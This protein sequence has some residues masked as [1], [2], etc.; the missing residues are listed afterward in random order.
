MAKIETTTAKFKAGIRLTGD[1]PE[2]RWEST[3]YLSVQLFDASGAMALAGR[4]L[5]VEIPKEG[6]VSLESDN[7][8]KVFHADV[9]FQDY[10]LDLGDGIK[11]QVPAVA[12][13]DE[14]QERHVPGIAFAFANLLV[15][16]RR[17]VAVRGARI[18]LTGP[19]GATLELITNDVGHAEHG[20]AL[21]SGEYSV[22]C[23]LGSAKVTLPDYNL[24]LVLV[25]LEPVAGR[26]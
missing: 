13:K 22:A 16:D 9:P 12:N 8:G 21:P 17:G 19:D 10:E 15:R 5:T 24:G 4:T 2:I 20:E 11:V 14:V 3:G 6:R 25:R 1:A 18:A 26:S 7:D 23:D